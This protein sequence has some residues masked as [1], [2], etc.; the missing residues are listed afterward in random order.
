L[1]GGNGLHAKNSLSV[2]GFGEKS[3]Q[4]LPDWPDFNNFSPEPKYPP[5]G[6][7]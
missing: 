1:V 5:A 6:G 7:E 3:R 2:Q 4:A